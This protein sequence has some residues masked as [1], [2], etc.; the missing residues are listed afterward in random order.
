MLDHSEMVLGPFENLTNLVL[1][2]L[3]VVTSHTNPAYRQQEQIADT[4]QRRLAR[5]Q[6]FF[7]TWQLSS[8]I[9][10]AH[11]YIISLAGYGMKNVVMGVGTFIC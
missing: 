2:P 10:V 1:D 7:I 6:P 4:N 3:S 5:E 9:Q 8:I 11:T